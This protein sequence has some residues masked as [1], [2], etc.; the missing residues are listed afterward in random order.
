MSAEGLTVAF[1]SALEGSSLDLNSL[2]GESLPVIATES[3][4]NLEEGA[5]VEYT[6]EVATD[7]TFAEVQ[8][9]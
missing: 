7:D 6:M 8:T 2:V 3:M 5:K 1:G 9:P 4:D